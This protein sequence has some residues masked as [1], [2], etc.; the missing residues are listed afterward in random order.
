[1]FS[2]KFKQVLQETDRLI[3]LKNETLRKKG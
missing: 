1:L 3:Y 2:E